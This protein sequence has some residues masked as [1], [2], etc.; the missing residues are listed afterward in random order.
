MATH[1]SVLAWRIP[2][3]GKPDELPSMGSHRVWHDWRDLAKK[4]KNYFLLFLRKGSW[5]LCP[6]HFD[7]VHNFYL[8]TLHLNNIF[9]VIVVQSLRHVWLFAT[10]CTAALQASLSFTI[11]QNL[12]KFMSIESVML[13]IA[14]MVKNPSAMQKTWV[15]SLGWENALEK[16]MVTH[17]S[18]LAWEIPWTEEPGW[19]KSIDC[20]ELDMT[21]GLST[22]MSIST[23]VKKYL[24]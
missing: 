9:V 24:G 8:C 10:P 5:V 14:P 6:V 3:M 15:W 19:L 12:L 1:S 20:K 13:S 17:S 16:E 7:K 18:I 2:G 11:S 4:E 23:W 21:E 22:H